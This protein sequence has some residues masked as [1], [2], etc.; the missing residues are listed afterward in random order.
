MLRTLIPRLRCPAGG[1]P[2][3]LV[4][5]DGDW[6]ETGELLCAANGRRY[7]IRDG[8]PHLYVEDERWRPKAREAE[9]WVQLHK[10]RQLYGEASAPV[11]VRLPYVDH[12]P[13]LSTAREFDVALELGAPLAGKWVLDVGAG[14]GW[15][16]AQFAVRGA[17]AV[18]LE[19]NPDRHVG[20]GRSIDTMAHTGARFSPVIGDSENMP[21]ADG[22]FDIAFASAALHHTSDIGLVLTNIARVLRPGGLLLAMHEPCAADGE[23]VD[24][25][26]EE[27]RS[28]GINENHP[29]LD[30]YRH[31]LRRAALSEQAIFAWQAYGV[32]DESR[33]IWSRELGVPGPAEVAARRPR[34]E[35]LLGR[36]RRPANP[37]L[38]PQDWMDALLR[39]IGGGV[40]IAARRA[41]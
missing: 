34:W 19:I 17:N 9:G 37:R 41:P 12:E 30:G 26:L 4:S 20:L 8:M 2:L 7:P 23:D 22:A 40:I 28:Y 39:R 24:P 38:P 16:A 6:V 27:E 35:R 13:W 21:F 14:R 36:L 32:S 31:A 25:L 29:G 1:G 10:D 18:A 3:T 5:D 15:A 33:A 11:D